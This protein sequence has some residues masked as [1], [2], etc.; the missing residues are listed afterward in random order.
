MSIRFPWLV[1]IPLFAGTSLAQ[2]TLPVKLAPLPSGSPMSQVA[3]PAPGSSSALLVGGSDACANCDLIGGTGTFALNCAAATTGIEGQS[4]AACLFFGTTGIANDVWFCWAATFTGLM[5]LSTCGATAMDTKMAVYPSAGC[6]TSGPLACNDDACSALQSTLCCPVTAGTIYAIQ[7]GVYPGSAPGTGT[8][9]IS[10][11]TTCCQSPTI[12]TQPQDA[13][14]CNGGS[15]T[16]SVAASGTGPIS[17]Q[18]YRNGGAVGG[19]T[20]TTFSTSTAG[21]YFVTVTNACSAI[22]SVTVTVSVANTPSSTISPVGVAGCPNSLGATLTATASGGGPYTYQWTRN[23]IPISGATASSYGTGPPSA[24]TIGVYRVIV[25]NACGSATSLNSCSM[26]MYDPVTITLQPVSQALCTGGSVSFSVTA[27]GQPTISYQWKRN[28]FPI[29]GAISPSYSISPVATSDSASYTCTCTN[30]CGPVTSSAAALT[31]QPTT[32]I[33][34]WPTDQTVC[35]GSTL[36][37]DFTAVGGTPLNVEWRNPQGGVPSGTTHLTLAPVTLANS[38]QWRCVA[39]SPCG[40]L[41]EKTFVLTVL[42]AVSILTQPVST[43]VCVGSVVSFSVTAT[44]AA[45]ISYQWKRNGVAIGGATASTY[46]IGSAGVLDDGSYT[47]TCTNTCGSATSD[48][49][50]LTILTSQSIVSFCHC[51]VGNGPC[52]ATSSST[53]GNP[54]PNSAPGRGCVNSLAGSVGARLDASGVASVNSDSLVLTA[55]GVSPGPILLYQSNSSTTALFNMDGLW[56]LGGTSVLLCATTSG[57]P[58]GFSANT[59]TFPN[60]V[61]PTGLASLGSVVGGATCVYQVRY[62]DYS[63]WCTSNTVNSTNALSIVWCP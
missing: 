19:A 2:S 33:T 43:S 31:V 24:S 11:A 59:A 53:P 52:F 37:L 29:S 6:P 40:G 28:G 12:V 44:G 57:V 61:C 58:G 27:T 1:L 7:I 13:T 23:G 17:Y 10:Q 15:T 62:K 56:C 8:F 21:T 63:A 3:P 22:T 55:T 50:I 49:A 51:D 47:C 35:E 16:L 42:A 20:S 54:A 36:N 60:T 46:S 26:S 48:P 18:W 5:S 38:G 41:V 39:A 30:T 45:T 9:T 14:A 4:N 25:T 32:A 34:S